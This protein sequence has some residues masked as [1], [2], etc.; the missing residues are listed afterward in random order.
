MSQELQTRSEHSRSLEEA[1]RFRAI[2]TLRELGLFLALED[3]DS[4]H[5]RVGR[6]SETEP[7]NVD[8]SFTN[9]GD[10]SGN[11]N[12]NS[13]ATLYTGSAQDAKDFAMERARIIIRPRFRKHFEDQARSYTPEQRHAWLARENQEKQD[14]WDSLNDEQRQRYPNG[15]EFYTIEDFERRIWAEGEHLAREASEEERKAVW[16]RESAGLRVEVHDIVS[17]DPD[18]M[19]L[20]FDFD[21]TKLDEASQ[22]IYSEALRAI[23]LPITEGSPLSFEHRHAAQPVFAAIQEAKNT[24]VS[25]SD[26]AALAQNTG[27]DEAVVL[28]LASGYNAL[29]IA[30]QRP[31]YLANLLLDNSE[32][33]VNADLT[34]ADK[35]QQ[36]PV[37]LEYAARYFREAHVVGAL[38]H[39]SSITLG[40]N[41]FAVSLFDLE[42]ATTR[43]A[44][45]KQRQDTW[46]QLGHISTS[47]S[48]IT[49]RETFEQNAL[50]K[51]LLDPHAKPQKLIDAAKQIDGYEE[52]F[53]A[54][55]GTWE[56][57]TL[58]EHTETVLRNFDENYADDLPV[59]MLAP[60]RLAIIA[61]DL[62]KPAATSTG[63]RHKEK[64]HNQVQA[65]DFLTKLV[66]DQGL[67]DLLLA[68][69]GDGADL[70]HQIQI[71]GAGPSAEKR[72]RTLAVNTIT[73]VNGPEGVNE[74]QING[75]V[76][77]CK[78]L[79]L[80]DGGAY[81]SMAIT[82]KSSGFGRHRNAPSFNS[83]FA[84][85]VGFGRRRIKLRGEDEHPAEQDLT[86]TASGEKS[87]I[88]FTRPG[89]G[90][91]APKI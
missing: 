5:G 77:M 81:T 74:E 68:V 69:I 46:R 44:L 25:S 36:V 41:I 83:S 39:V 3:L 16:E 42:K 40:R 10:D 20:D 37:N 62:G 29:Q 50:L 8:P 34:I 30:L 47:L 45:H 78:I 82:R 12:V 27:L 17:A 32:D 2:H 59:E 67:K 57:F 73:K 6:D 49:R 31:G 14:W 38:Q 24:M 51:L 56:H 1:D 13:R 23:M 21:I 64:E 53:D 79:Q 28:Q 71:R 88:K 60:M 84:H 18:A 52:I 63:Q 76:E 87:R 91:K 85:P 86:P 15:P 75:F 89:A 55:T 66:I 33:I 35:T 61:H 58:A 7:W 9:G 54:D 72:M 43:Q 90:R 22:A 48:S 11:S 65:N 4:Y 26:I 80:C 70:A 19:I